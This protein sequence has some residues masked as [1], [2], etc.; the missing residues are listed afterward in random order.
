MVVE[1]EIKKARKEKGKVPGW[2]LREHPQG[3]GMLGEKDDYLCTLTPIE[4]ITN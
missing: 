1:I 2:I 4:E 3:T